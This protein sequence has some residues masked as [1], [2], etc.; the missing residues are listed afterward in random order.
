VALTI[1]SMCGLDVAAGQRIDKALMRMRR[2]DWLK[3]IHTEL[4]KQWTQQGARRGPQ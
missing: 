1:I 4:W 2:G 3:T